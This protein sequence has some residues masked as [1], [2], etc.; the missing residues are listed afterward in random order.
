[1]RL[2]T[3]MIPSKNPPLLRLLTSSLHRNEFS[4][5]FSLSRA[6][7]NDA[8]DADHYRISGKPSIIRSL[9]VRR[10]ICGVLNLNLIED[11]NKDIET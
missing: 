6:D 8:I 2:E 9:L 10:L 11:A 4:E 5:S 3:A 7:S 1:M